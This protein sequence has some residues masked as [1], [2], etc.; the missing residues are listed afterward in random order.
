MEIHS[1]NSITSSSCV[2]VK[3]FSHVLIQ[4]TTHHVQSRKCDPLDFLLPLCDPT[5]LWDRHHSQSHTNWNRNRR[6]LNNFW[7][8]KAQ[9][10]HLFC[11]DVLL[12]NENYTPWLMQ[13][14]SLT[15]ISSMAINPLLVVFLWPENMTWG[16]KRTRINNMKNNFTKHRLYLKWLFF[17]FTCVI[18]LILMVTCAF[19]HS[20]FWLPL[21][22]HTSTSE[23][24]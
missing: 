13:G 20:G 3:P 24:F 23:D 18:L 22:V 19:I 15:V 7:R 1:G 5:D 4:C 6:N 2:E 11:L 14:P 12:V 17:I 10:K 8:K 16:Q 21:R 9:L